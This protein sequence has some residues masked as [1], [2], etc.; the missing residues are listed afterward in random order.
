MEYHSEVMSDQA[1]YG[2]VSFLAPPSIGDALVTYFV[3]LFVHIDVRSILFWITHFFY[4]SLPPKAKM[5]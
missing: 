4:H 1:E 2:C 5:S 3:V